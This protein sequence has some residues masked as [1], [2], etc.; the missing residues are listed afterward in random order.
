MITSL[1]FTNTIFHW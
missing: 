1:G